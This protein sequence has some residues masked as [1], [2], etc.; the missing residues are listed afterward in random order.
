MENT[1][2][3]EEIDL[4]DV[5]FETEDQTDQI[6]EET[7]NDLNSEENA[8]SDDNFVGVNEKS[9]SDTGNEND[10]FDNSEN[11]E[12]KD[13]E[14]KSKTIE[15]FR[16]QTCEIGFSKKGE[17]KYHKGLEHTMQCYV[18]KEE[19]DSKN[20][21]KRHFTKH[22]G[23]SKEGKP[24]NEKGLV[25]IVKAPEKP[26]KCNFCDKAYADEGSLQRHRNNVHEME[27]EQEKKIEKESKEKASARNFVPCGFCKVE[28]TKESIP[29]HLRI[30]VVRKKVFSG[31]ITFDE[32]TR[33]RD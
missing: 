30:C 11:H 3:Q 6:E 21:F 19:F 23:F 4:D 14:N 32:L 33:F 25:I 20:D 18:C 26:C 15:V 16:C 17:M 22:E 12:T 13:V 7:E 24:V 10:P 31:E 8:L 9:D 5:V 29:L 28:M 27:S 2:K 1:I